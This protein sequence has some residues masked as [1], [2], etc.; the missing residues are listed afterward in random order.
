M[1]G[2]SPSCRVGG[3][4]VPA[5]NRRA[6]KAAGD[7]RSPRRFAPVRT[8]GPSQRWSSW[9]AGVLSRYF[10]GNRPDNSGLRPFMA[11]VPFIKEQGPSVISASSKARSAMASI[12][13]PAIVLIAHGPLSFATTARDFADVAVR[14]LAQDVH[15]KGW[16]AFSAPTGQGTWDIHLMR[17]DGSSRRPLTTTP[18]A[19]EFWPQ[20][21]RD[22]TKLLY[23]RVRRD[24]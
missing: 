14:T 17:P 19:N 5:G 3:T 9:S 21:S 11:G 6:G 20:F 23:R 13:A 16:V 8:L 18:D 7:C 15:D 24:E 1:A 2:A 22:G 12:L 10:N 4:T